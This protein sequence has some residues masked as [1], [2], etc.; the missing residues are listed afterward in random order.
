M[1]RGMLTFS[2]R[3]E[4]PVNRDKVEVSKRGKSL[5]R[6][7]LGQRGACCDDSREMECRE[8]CQDGRASVVVGR[9][10]KQA[11]LVQ[12]ERVEC[13]PARDPRSVLAKGR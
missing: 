7:Q 13:C 12:V 2:G 5:G 9:E 8:V 10:G 4:R 6:E 11:D 1:H 3:E